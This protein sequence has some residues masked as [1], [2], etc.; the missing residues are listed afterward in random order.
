MQ[1]SSALRASK[2][3]TRRLADLFPALGGGLEERDNAFNSNHRSATYSESPHA[4]AHEQTSKSALA[5]AIAA[6][7]AFSG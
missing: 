7:L 4:C 1:A 2:D 5:L 3:Q 6:F